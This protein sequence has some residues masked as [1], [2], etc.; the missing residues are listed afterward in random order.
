MASSAS[1]PL[2]PRVCVGYIYIDRASY[3]TLLLS[4]VKA[5]GGGAF[6]CAG[7]KIQSGKRWEEIEFTPLFVL[8]SMIK[9]KRPR[10]RRRRRLV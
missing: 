1:S 9:K 4:L 6:V 8:P 10:R 3:I 5:E 2:L 7:W